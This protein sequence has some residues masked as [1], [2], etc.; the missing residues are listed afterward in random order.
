MAILVPHHLK[1]DGVKF[2]TPAS[3][4]FQL[5]LM[6][7]GSD[8]PV[9]L[10]SHQAI[11][12]RITGTQEFLLIRKGMASV[13]LYEDMLKNL[14]SKPTHQIELTSGDGILLISGAHSIQFSE[15]CELLEIKQ[16]PYVQ[17]TDKILHD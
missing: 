6:E 14:D 8:S 4:Y 1:V 15:N 7:R 11:E 2:L 5:G 3:N 16:G 9:A 13:S 12:R 17:G 10:H